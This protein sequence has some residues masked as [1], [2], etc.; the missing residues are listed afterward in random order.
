MILSLNDGGSELCLTVNVRPATEKILSDG[1][2]VAGINRII[3]GRSD[4]LGQGST[5]ILH[6]I[7]TSSVEMFRYLQAYCWVSRSTNDS[8]VAC[9]P[10]RSI[11]A[12]AWTD[13]VRAG[14]HGLGSSLALKLFPLPTWKESS[15]QRQRITREAVAVDREELFVFFHSRSF[16]WYLRIYAMLLSTSLL[17]SFKGV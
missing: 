7:K 17:P 15:V 13:Q 9:F 6:H 12:W 8:D 3:Q 5:C 11:L 2:L 10:R 4:S 1:S 16:T 14:W